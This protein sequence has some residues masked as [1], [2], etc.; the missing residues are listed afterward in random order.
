MYIDGGLFIEVN[1]GDRRQKTT[2]AWGGIAKALLSDE[3][4]NEEKNASGG[5]KWPGG[6]IFLGFTINT[7]ETPI[8]LP[9]EKRA[10]ATTLFDEIFAQF[11]SRDMRLVTLQRLRGDLEH[12][13]STNFLRDFVTAPADALLG[14]SDGTGI[15]INCGLPNVWRAFWESMRALIS[16]RKDE[17]RRAG[18]PKGSLGL[19]LPAEQRFSCLRYPFNVFWVS[20]DATPQTIAGVS[21]FGKEYFVFD[22]IRQ[23]AK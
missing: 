19:L 11:G 17:H 5:E 3:A 6:H 22:A 4:I 10:G 14:C 9:E 23:P 8:R 15:W 20:G 1:I 7:T 16:I 13:K 21:W 18:L 12:F 2:E